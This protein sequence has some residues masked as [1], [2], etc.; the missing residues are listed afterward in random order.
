M[1]GL[2]VTSKLSFSSGVYHEKLP[3]LNH[4]EHRLHT[5]QSHLQ[6]QSNLFQNSND[7]FIEIENNNDNPKG[8][9]EPQKT[10]NSQSHPEKEY[11]V[12]GI[13]L[14]GCKLYYKSLVIKLIWHWHKIDTWTNGRGLRDQK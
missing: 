6:Y 10:T 11:K 12:G 2:N 9:M 8:H 1:R 13:T 5:T 4:E 7:I 14:P 3:K